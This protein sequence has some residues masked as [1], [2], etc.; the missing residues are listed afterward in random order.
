M[1]TTLRRPRSRRRPHPKPAVHPP[2]HVAGRVVT[3]GLLTPPRLVG[4]PLAL[5]LRH[6]ENHA[7]DSRR[8]PNFEAKALASA[9]K[10]LRSRDEGAELGDFLSIGVSR[11]LPKAPKFEEFTIGLS[12]GYEAGSLEEYLDP[13][14]SYG[15]AVYGPHKFKAPTVLVCSGIY[16]YVAVGDIF[17]RIHGR[18]PDLA[19]WLVA[20]LNTLGPLSESPPRWWQ[21]VIGNAFWHG[22]ADETEAI[23]N[24]GES[25]DDKWDGP[26]LA[27]YHELVPE[28]VRTAS[29]KLLRDK[30]ANLRMIAR[31]A[32]EG[33][34][35]SGMFGPDGKRLDLSCLRKLL[36]HHPQS[37]AYF[38]WKGNDIITQ[39][40]DEDFQI[41]QQSGINTNAFAGV[42][43]RDLSRAAEKLTE[44]YDALRHLDAL[45]CSFRSYGK[46]HKL[47][48][49]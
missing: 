29:G 36:I 37:P 6:R 8:A 49:R 25:A 45:L 44:F 33:I 34:T 46:K 48:T 40:L 43:A 13:G 18:D 19:R 9:R 35:V 3:A 24:Y 26:T 5:T 7:D 32:A 22:E 1:P 16:A 47:P 31:A 39:A 10:F 4:V 2:T 38:A 14:D 27:Q 41:R 17:T 12:Y 21:A 23:A 20:L 42:D 15:D 11:A 30:I 28:W